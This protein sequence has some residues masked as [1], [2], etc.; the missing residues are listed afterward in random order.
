MNT[1]TKPRSVN[2]RNIK[3]GDHVWIE[4]GRAKVVIPETSEI[5]ELPRAWREAIV[6]KFGKNRAERTNVYV[7]FVKGVQRGK[8]EAQHLFCCNPALRGKDKPLYAKEHAGPAGEG[9][10]SLSRED[11]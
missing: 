3:L 7:R 11:C 1:D 10:F 6:V 8:R 2:W 9:V 4:W 5:R